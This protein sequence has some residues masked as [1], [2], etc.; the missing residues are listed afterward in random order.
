MHKEFTTCPNCGCTSAEVRPGGIYCNL[1][2]K[3][4]RREKHMLS[5]AGRIFSAT[6]K[7]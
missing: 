5:K 1:C 4:C 2:K 3:F 6:Y 7:R